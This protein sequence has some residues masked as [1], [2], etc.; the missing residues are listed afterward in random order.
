MLIT[1][2]NPLAH[3]QSTNACMRRLIFVLKMGHQSSGYILSPVQYGNR[4]CWEQVPFGEIE[5]GIIC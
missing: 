2:V 5:E 4:C 1:K 3:F